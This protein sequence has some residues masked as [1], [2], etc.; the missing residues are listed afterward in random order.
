MTRKQSG[1]ALIT[2]LLVVAIAALAATA[3]L[4]SSQLSIHRTTALR[5]TEQGWWLARGVEAWV[6]E[7]LK[8][9]DAK[10]DGLDEDWAQPVDYLPVD[11]GFVR[12]RLVDQQG[13]FNL[14]NLKRSASPGD[15]VYGKQFIHLLENLQDVTA[16]TQDL[17][18]AIR[19]WIDEG[20]D[21]NFPGAEDSVYLNLSPPYRTADQPF[22]AVSELLAIQGMTA[23]LYNA[24]MSQCPLVKDGPPGRCITVLPSSNTAVNVNTAPERVL[25]SLSRQVDDAKLQSFLSEREEKPDKRMAEFE[26]RKIYNPPLVTASLAIQSNF[27]SLQGEVFVGSSRVALYS[28]I[29]RSQQAGTPVTLTVFAHSTGD[30]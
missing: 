6:V 5:D 1:V 2:A 14:N 8:N 11:Q 13:L 18:P 7:I 29:Q 30:D 3:L 22:S 21:A 9:D 28:L 19:D 20:Q 24:L 12:G 23:E 16:P 4:S 26:G 27:F 25:R 17:V 15:D 10:Y